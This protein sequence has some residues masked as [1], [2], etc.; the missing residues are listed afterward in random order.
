MWLIVA[1]GVVILFNLV[2]AQKIFSENNLGFILFISAIFYWLYFVLKA[3]FINPQITASVDKT[4]KVIKDGVYGLVRHPIYAADIVLAWGVFFFWPTRRVLVSVI[5][6]TLVL[7]FWMKLEE[8]AL[9]KRFGQGYKE[10]QKRV[11]MIFPKIFK[12]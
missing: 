10:Y 2:T 9:T 7:L 6:L 4:I 8:W 3:A 1:I 11:P 12:K 5:W